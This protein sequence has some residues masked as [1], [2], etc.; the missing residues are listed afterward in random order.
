MRAQII[1]FKM[2]LLLL[3]L[4]LL[5]SCWIC[6]K[7][8]TIECDRAVACG[9]RGVTVPN[10]NTVRACDFKQSLLAACSSS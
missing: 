3:L 7:V 9:E 8:F 2:L 1:P 5:G 6:R 10:N 4:L